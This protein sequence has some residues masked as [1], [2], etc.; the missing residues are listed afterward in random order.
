MFGLKVLAHLYIFF[1]LACFRAFTDAKQSRFSCGNPK[2]CLRGS[3]KAASFGPPAKSTQV[4]FTCGSLS[5]WTVLG[6]DI[7][8]HVKFS[9]SP[10]CSRTLSE[11]AHSRFR[12]GDPKLCLPRLG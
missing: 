10:V 4:Y 5:I 11:A 1:S 6:L 12:C 9:I 2:L 8:S 7:L 3:S